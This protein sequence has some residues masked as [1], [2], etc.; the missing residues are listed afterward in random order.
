MTNLQIL[1]GNVY[2]AIP[3]PSIQGV[4]MVAPTTGSRCVIGFRNDSETFPYII[5]FIDDGSSIG[6]Y[7]PATFV[8]TGIPKF[9]V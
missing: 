9:M 6:K 1:R 7:G 5:S 4:Q 3:C 2:Q 8:D